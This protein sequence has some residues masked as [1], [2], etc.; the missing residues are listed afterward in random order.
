MVKLR[1]HEAVST[2]RGALEYGSELYVNERQKM[3]LS[4][5][6]L[7]NKNNLP[8]GVSFTLRGV[9]VNCA[10]MSMLYTH[11]I[12]N[13]LYNT[14]LVFKMRDS[15]PSA[16]YSRVC[17]VLRLWRIWLIPTYRVYTDSMIL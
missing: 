4:L 7:K 2:Q 11:S 10:I 8:N 5:G 16:R 1:Y 13:Q 15:V 17:N 12:G 9:H 6:L 14:L 3:T